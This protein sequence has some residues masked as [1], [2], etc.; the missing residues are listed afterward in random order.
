MPCSLWRGWGAPGWG[1]RPGVGWR[2]LQRTALLSPPPPSSLPCAWEGGDP[3]SRPSRVPRP[4]LL[5]GL[6]PPLDGRLLPGWRAG[7]ERKGRGGP[8]GVFAPS[9]VAFELVAAGFEPAPWLAGCASLKGN[10][11]ADLFFF[12]WRGW[13]LFC[14]TVWRRA[15]LPFGLQ[16]G[17][18]LPVGC[19]PEP[20]PPG[21]LGQSRWFLFSVGLAPLAVAADG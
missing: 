10:L 6:S 19:R 20:S 9:L 4:C 18:A 7:L 1:R 16:P 14:R 11:G 21:C 8:P 12:F 15:P 2:T 13:G 5:R 3:V 17:E